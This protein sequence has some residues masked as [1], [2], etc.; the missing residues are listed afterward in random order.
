MEPFLA[1]GLLIKGLVVGVLSSAPMG[2]VGVLTVQRTLN[3]GRW[4]GFV[5]GV[6]AT[7][8]DFVYAMVAAL[9]IGLVMEFIERPQS[10]LSLKVGG[11]LMLFAFGVYTFLS[12]PAAN[13]PASQRKGTLMHNGITGF[14]VTFSNPLILLLFLALFARFDFVVPGHPVEQTIGFLG[15]VAGAL[16][17]WL[18]LT[19]IVDK[20]RNRFCMETIRRIN[21]IIGLVVIV[22]AVLGLLYTLMLR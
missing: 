14:L 5:T 1:L 10:L 22:A 8:S 21:R 16:V 18:F 19:G 2:P 3:K 17:W 20:V 6:G 4:Y 15:F 12:T 13:R 7:L 11:A 9:G